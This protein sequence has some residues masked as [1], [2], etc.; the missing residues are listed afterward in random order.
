[1]ING[2]AT[3]YCI[4]YNDETVGFI[5]GKETNLLSEYLAEWNKD[6]NLHTNS[7]TAWGS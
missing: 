1:M 7:K 6:L 4:K 5:L 2:Y 3:N